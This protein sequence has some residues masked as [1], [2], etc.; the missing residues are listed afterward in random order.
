M[1]AIGILLVSI[2]SLFALHEDPIYYFDMR[3]YEEC[4][5]VVKDVAVQNGSSEQQIEQS[6]KEMD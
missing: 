6:M 1:A 2:S 4:K 5:E 3:R